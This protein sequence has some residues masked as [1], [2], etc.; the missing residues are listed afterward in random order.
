VLR[1]YGIKKY[2][3]HGRLNLISYMDILLQVIRLRDK[4]LENSRKE[5]LLCEYSKVGFYVTVVPSN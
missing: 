2:W 1:K 3:D 5:L 4:K